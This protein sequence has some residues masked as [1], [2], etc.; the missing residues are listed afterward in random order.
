MKTTSERRYRGVNDH[1]ARKT[2]RRMMIVEV[3]ALA[4][5]EGGQKN[6]D[7]IVR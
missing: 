4:V 7:E 3:D 5:A 6:E 1:A 2:W